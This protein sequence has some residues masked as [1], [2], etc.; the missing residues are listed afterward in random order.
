ML[1]DNSSKSARS[2]NK[3]LNWKSSVKST[4]TINE[5]TVLRGYQ[6]LFTIVCLSIIKD[7]KI[8]S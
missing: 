3:S 5:F 7:L 6:Y 1:A 8:L 2:N 4:N